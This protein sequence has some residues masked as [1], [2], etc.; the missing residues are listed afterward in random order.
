V[1]PIKQRFPSVYERMLESAAVQ[2]T[3][4]QLLHVLGTAERDVLS[5]ADREALRHEFR[6]TYAY[7]DQLGFTAYH[8]AAAT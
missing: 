6:P 3:K 2:W 8:D 7:L 4:Q 5:G 1:H